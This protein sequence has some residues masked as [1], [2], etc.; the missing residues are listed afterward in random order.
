MIVHI[1][2][3]SYFLESF[4]N[5]QHVTVRKYRGQMQKACLQ[6]QTAPF[7]ELGRLRQ[8]KCYFRCTKGKMRIS[9]LLPDQKLHLLFGIWKGRVQGVPSKYQISMVCTTALQWKSS[10]KKVNLYHQFKSGG[11]RFENR[12]PSPLRMLKTY[13]LKA[14]SVPRDHCL[15]LKNKT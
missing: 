11:N 14:D 15:L 12:I 10:H 5:P 2:L 8:Q 1:K 4:S 13:F 3:H 6:L 9:N 7:T